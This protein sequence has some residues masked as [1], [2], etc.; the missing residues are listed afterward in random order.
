MEHRKTHNMQNKLAHS[1]VGKFKR[2]PAR[3]TTAIMRSYLR[4]ALRRIVSVVLA[5]NK[6]ACESTIETAERSGLLVAETL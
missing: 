3:E 2:G 5:K 1:G 4:L 6:S